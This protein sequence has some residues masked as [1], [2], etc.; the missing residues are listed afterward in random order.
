MKLWPDC[1]VSESAWQ[2]AAFLEAGPSV[3]REFFP[4]AYA[5]KSTITNR[6]MPPIKNLTAMNVNGFM[7]DIASFTTTN[8]VPQITVTKSKRE[9]AT[10]W[11]I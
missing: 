8:V 7:A 11:L 6:K 5:R 4:A 9:S 1:P 3:F 2:S 10:I